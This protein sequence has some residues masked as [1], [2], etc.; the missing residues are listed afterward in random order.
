M[1]DELIRRGLVRDVIRQIQ[2]LRKSSGFELSD[3]I[4]LDLDGADD[5]D[6]SD[7]EL[8]ANEVLALSIRRGA[9]QGEGHLLDLD[10]HD[11]LRVWLSPGNVS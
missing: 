1:N 4:E 8:L 7:L 6:E 9:G 5:L 2:E 10:D 11:T 3:R